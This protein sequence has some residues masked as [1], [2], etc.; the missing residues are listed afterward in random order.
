[1]KRPYIIVALLWVAVVGMGMTQLHGYMNTPGQADAA[2]TSLS[3]GDGFER[4]PGQPHM[5]VFIHRQC[6]C[7]KATLQQLID[8]GEKSLPMTVVWI[9]D[10]DDA[11]R[12][13][14]ALQ[15]L[16]DRLKAQTLS[17]TDG[18]L[19][20]RFGA[21]TSGHVVVYDADGAL[22][23]TGGLTPGRGMVGPSGG[24]LALVDIAGG[25]APDHAA[26]P[27]FGCPL[28]HT[29]TQG[30]ITREAGVQVPLADCCPKP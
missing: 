26:L 22:A 23:Y 17:D 20:E 4:L 7:S 18:R 11:G 30:V 28:T 8:Q 2:P 12:N 5:L 14:K 6:P 15:A 24:V 19:A 25:Q 27:V 16:A 13:A 10:A 21:R 1:M 3:V 29:K 9:G